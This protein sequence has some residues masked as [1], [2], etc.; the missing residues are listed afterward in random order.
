MKKLLVLSLF[1]TMLIQNAFAA[2]WFWNRHDPETMTAV[3]RISYETDR[4]ERALKNFKPNVDGLNKGYK[5]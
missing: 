3:E 4:V 2:S 1:A 5:L